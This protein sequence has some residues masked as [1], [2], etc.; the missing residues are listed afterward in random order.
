MF[1]TKGK[2]T[3]LY[4][5]TIISLSE[6]YLI[7]PLKILPLKSLKQLAYLLIQFSDPNISK[8]YPMGMIL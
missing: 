6:I 4:L 7:S 2:Y 5:K 1:Y 3:N 8:P